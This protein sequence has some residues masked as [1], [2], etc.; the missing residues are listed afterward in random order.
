MDLIEIKLLLLNYS[1]VLAGFM[2]A[3]LRESVQ[4]PCWSA[5][6]FQMFLVGTALTLI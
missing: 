4:S 3:H 5:D 2:V 6:A 1:A